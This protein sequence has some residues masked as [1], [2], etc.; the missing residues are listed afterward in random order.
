MSA[1]PANVS[2][3]NFLSQTRSALLA[4]FAALGE[5]PFRVTQV[6]KWVYH[7]GVLSF[8]QMS[9]VSRV[10]RERLATDFAIRVWL[11]KF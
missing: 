8:D 5:R 10:V 1:A 7:R 3:Q 4:Y 9:D 2:T 11:R 6:M